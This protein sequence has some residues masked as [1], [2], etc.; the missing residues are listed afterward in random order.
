MQYGHFDDVAREYVITRPDTPRPWSNYLGSTEYGAIVTNHAGGYSFYKSGATGRFLRMRFNSIP[1]D[2]PGRLFYLR[3]KESKDFWSAAWQPVGKPLDEY[4][5]TCRHGTAYT[6]IESRYAG[7]AT[8]STYF[9]PLSQTFEYWRLRVTNTTDR[10][11]RLSVFTYCEFANLWT[12]SQDLVNLQYSQFINKATLERGILGVTGNPNYDFDGKDLT[13][14]N[15]TWMALTGAP[16]AGVESTRE[17]FLGTYGGYAAPEVVVHGRCSGFLGEGDNIVGGLQADLVLK[18]GETRELIVLLGLGT[19]KSHGRKTVAKF[20]DPVRC[21]AEFAKLKAAWHAPLENLQVETPDADFDHMV[22]VW[23]SYNALITYAWSRS[24]SLVYNGERD[25]LGFRDTVQDILGATALLKEG[26]KDRLELMLTGQL[27]NG[28][29]IPVIKPFLHR[30]GH[31]APPPDE[32]YRSDDCLWFFNAVPAYVAETGDVAFYEKVLPYAD[33]GEASVFKHL[34]RALEFNLERTGR[35]G[36]PC[37]L[38][39]DWNDCI[40]LGYH[41]ESVFVAF[42]VRLGL[43]VYAEIAE[44]LGKPDEAAWAFAERDRLDAAIQ[45]VCWDGKWFIWAIGQDGT[46]YGTKNF[47]EGQVYM[48][49]QVWAVISGAATRD[50]AKQA[51]LSMKQKCA[52]PYGITLCAPPF[53]KADPEIMK[54]T[55]FNTGIKENAGIFSHTQ[56]WAVIAEAMRGN[57]DQAYAYYQAFMP[58]AYNRRAEV[59]QVEPYVHCQTTYSKFNVNEGASRVPWLSGTASW[60][61]YSATHWILGIR[62][63]IDGLRIDPCIPKAW[64]GFKMTRVFRGRKLDIEVRNPKGRCKGVASLFVDGVPVPGDLVPLENLG[65]GSRIVAV[66]G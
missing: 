40:K 31:E 63:E 13:G 29:A 54:A 3:D 1:L 11:R 48:N 15:R 19:V 58:S 51:L 28:G 45:K 60:S 64:K 26:V 65:D 10:R 24:A 18:P 35:N 43:G 62:P 2:Q 4:Q 42:Q 5:S 16:L 9:V 6:I 23:N 50:Q 38:S 25:G 46:V 49:T 41:G 14:C 53:V 44:R 55:L 56:S 21:E 30:P 36:L 27:A 32:E 37:G 12:T 39:A 22:N 20:A 33:H 8:E 34:R 47:K 59:R 57:G 61:C 66:L 52:T 17:R 7:I